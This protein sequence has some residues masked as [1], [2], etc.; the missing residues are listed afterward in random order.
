MRAIHKVHFARRAGE[1][2][3]CHIHKIVGEYDIAQHTFGALCLLRVLNPEPSSALFWAVT[4]HD[5]P[6]FITGDIP[7]PSKR[8]A[9]FDNEKYKEHE[10]EILEKYGFSWPYLTQEEEEWLNAVDSLEL[11]SD[12]DWETKLVSSKVKEYRL[13]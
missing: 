2:R 9:W 3:R 1:V 10:K 12:R 5:L 8:Q 6:E 4:L 11:L 7:S 13:K